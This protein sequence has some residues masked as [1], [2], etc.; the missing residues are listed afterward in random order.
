MTEEFV[1][2]VFTITAL[3]SHIGVV[4]LLVSYLLF[5]KK[6]KCKWFFGWIGKNGILFAF[7][8]ALASMLGSLYYSDV[9][10]LEPCVMCWY[11]RICM[12]PIV[13]LMGFSLFKKKDKS[14]ISY[15]I[16]LSVIGSFV[17]IYHIFLQTSQR[18]AITC[19]PFATVSC[20]DIYFVA[21]KYIT[22]PVLSL[23]A[24]AIIIIAL[25]FS[26]KYSK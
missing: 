24:F 7:L 13:F 8:T 11:A 15:V 9:I 2:Q 22:F 1:T 4:V 3:I 21:F 25:L 5:N 20:S 14:I 26:K 19:S 10:G 12:Y 6:E 18:V 16:L 23:T 17:N